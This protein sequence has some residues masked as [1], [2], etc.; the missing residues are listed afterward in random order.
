[1]KIPKEERK[2]LNKDNKDWK[3]KAVSYSSDLLLGNPIVTYYDKNS[4]I[5]NCQKKDKIDEEYIKTLKKN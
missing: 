2:K 4:E 5:V 3:T 1:M